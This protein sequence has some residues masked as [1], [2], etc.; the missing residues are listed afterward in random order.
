MCT[1]E[2]WKTLPWWKE[3]V[4]VIRNQDNE[5]LDS[6]LS[7]ALDKALDKVIDL[8]DN[9]EFVYDQKQVELKNACET[10]RC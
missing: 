10:Q 5:K 7:K 4:Q 3:A 6:K 9:G 8:I 1:I 2:H